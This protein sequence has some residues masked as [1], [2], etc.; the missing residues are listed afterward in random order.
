MKRK[1][2]KRVLSGGLARNFAV[3]TA[4]G[5]FRKASA[6]DSIPPAGEW[7]GR[8]GARQDGAG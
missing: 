5:A 8:C 4:Y 6:A 1:S 2:V 7:D 3:M